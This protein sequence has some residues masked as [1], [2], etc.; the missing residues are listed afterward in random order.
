MDDREK[1]LINVT[2]SNAIHSL[3][4]FQ[5]VHSMLMS[6]TTCSNSSNDRCKATLA[7]VQEVMYRLLRPQFPFRIF[8]FAGPVNSGLA[9]PSRRQLEVPN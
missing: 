2:R 4:V 3:T 7:T 1:L 5:P 8:Y 9:K 6:S